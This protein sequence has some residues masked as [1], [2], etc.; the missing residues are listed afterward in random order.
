MSRSRQ[1]TNGNRPASR[2][3]Y[4]GTFL[5]PFHQAHGK[6]GE[7]HPGANDEERNRKVRLPVFRGMAGTLNVARL[8][9]GHPA[10]RKKFLED[11]PEVLLRRRPSNDSFFYTDKMTMVISCDAPPL[12]T[13]HSEPYLVR[14]TGRR[15]N[16]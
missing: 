16:N 3:K 15:I 11:G 6:H 9:A 14:P 5:K 13:L 4:A 12:R 1:L 7:I 8:I 2:K 10:S